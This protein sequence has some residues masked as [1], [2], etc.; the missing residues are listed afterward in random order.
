MATDIT[1]Q[2]AAT[3]LTLVIAV[4]RWMLELMAQ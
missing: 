2:M 4:K 3:K 1:N